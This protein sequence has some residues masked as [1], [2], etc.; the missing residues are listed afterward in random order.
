MIKKTLT[1]F[2]YKLKY[3]YKYLL[4][5]QYNMYCM[6]MHLYVYLHI[7]IHATHT[8]YTNTN[9]YFINRFNSTINTML[10]V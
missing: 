8:Y 10:I 7:I 4:Y 1:K 3:L 9:I 5:N 2:Q 6:G